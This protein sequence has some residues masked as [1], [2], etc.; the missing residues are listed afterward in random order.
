MRAVRS[1]TWLGAPT[2][3]VSARQSSCTPE[4]AHRR[5]NSATRAGSTSPSNGQ[6]NDVA[7]V[8]VVNSPRSRAAA[9]T[10]AAIRIASSAVTF[11]LRPL[12]VSLTH[13]TTLTSSTPAPTARSSPLRFRISPA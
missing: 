4:S 5:A 6:P 8:I 10:S 7:S 12:K 13:T 2:P 9:T 3:T 11:W 1:M